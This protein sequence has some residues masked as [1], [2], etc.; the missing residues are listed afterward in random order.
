MTKIYK[1]FLFVLILMFVTLVACSSNDYAGV[2]EQDMATQDDVMEYQVYDEGGLR[3]EGSIEDGEI[4]APVDTTDRKIMYNAHLELTTR[5]YDQAVLF[6]EEEVADVAGYILNKETHRYDE[7]LRSSYFTIRIPEKN[8]QHF[9]NQ[10]ES[11]LFRVEYNAL[12]G[13]DVTDQYVDLNTRLNTQKQLEERLV[14]FL[15]EA[16]STEDLLQIS[17]DLAT[18]QLEIERLTGQLN[19]LDNRIDFATVDL[20]LQEEEISTIKDSDLNIWQRIKDQWT[21][22]YD[23]VIIFFSNLFVFIVGNLPV[24]IVFIAITSIIGVFV[25]RRYKKQ[26]SSD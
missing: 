16:A 6:I 7:R 1:V 12:S 26:S 9:L 22:S 19:Y 10:F 8:L 3:P 23:T 13:Q 17:R 2:S 14:S 20:T 4:D 5:K 24:I 18:V 15:E 25:R 11:D 21:R